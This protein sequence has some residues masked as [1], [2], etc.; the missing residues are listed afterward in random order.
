MPLTV[1][2][3]FERNMSYLNE[4]LGVGVSYDMIFRHYH[5]GE[6]QVATYVVNGFFQTLPNLLVQQ[7]F[8][9]LRADPPEDPSDALRQIFQERLHYSQVTQTTN[10]DEVVHQ[11]LAG[12]MGVIISGSDKAL[13]VDTRWYPD[14]DPEEPNNEQLV[15]GP[16]DGFI[17][18]LIFNTA[19][20]RRRMREPRL[21]FELI[22][23]ARRSHTDVAIGYIE[24]L[25]NPDLVARLKRSIQHIDAAGL[26]MGE[27]PVSEFLT[28]RAWNPLPTVR[29]TER[30]DVA[31]FHLLEGHAVVMV[32]TTP[33]AI[34]APSTLWNHIQHPEDYHVNPVAGTYMRWV[35]F[36]S[37]FLATLLVPVWLLLATHPALLAHLPWL[38]F[39]GPK[40]TS[41]FPLVWQFVL[42]EIAIDV[43]R[44]AILNTPHPMASTM[45]I[46]GAVILG[47]L[48]SKAGLFAPEVLVYMVIAAIASFAISSNALGQTA[49]LMR[50]SLI[51]L[52][53]V[54]GLAGLIAGLAGWLLLALTTESFGVPYLWP[55][56]PLN[57]MALR[58]VLIRVP[59][60]GQGRMRPAL[61]GTMDSTRRPGRPRH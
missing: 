35:E 56:V 6:Y 3:D 36:S 11:V 25:T 44:R 19:L 31:A 46:L 5:F 30:P 4:T 50:L 10:L 48:A 37:L 45:G 20:L 26:S 8:E 39:I 24:G 43:L 55:L 17:E 16:H 21:R 2:E 33:E 53:G 7:A 22:V 58:D 38:K 47:D 14:R 59:F 40:K 9:W 29:Y 12:P 41:G 1:A 51:I 52:V 28:G 15:H 57:L 18:T 61:L 42:A 54:G 23:A 34:I 60:T 49:R 32:D 13:V 27:Q